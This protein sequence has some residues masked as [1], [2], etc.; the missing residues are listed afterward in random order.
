MIENIRPYGRLL[1]ALGLQVFCF[2]YLVIGNG[3][4][5]PTFHLYGLLLLPLVMRKIPLMIIAFGTGLIAD[6]ATTSAGLHTASALVMAAMLP[7]INRLFAPREGY[8][9]LDHGQLHQHGFRWFAS[10]TFAAVWIHN[11]WLFLLEAGRFNLSGIALGK[12]TTSALLT[13]AIFIAVQALQFSK[14]SRR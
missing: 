3:W 12:A 13:T 9:V 4:G 2:Q 7:L 5:Y 6:M 14:R 11:I 8:D 1:L 10:R